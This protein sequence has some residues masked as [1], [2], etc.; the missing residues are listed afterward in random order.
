VA[1]PDI[2]DLNRL[3]EA[4]AAKLIIQSAR[5]IEYQQYYDGEF[6]IVALL[7]TEQ[8]RVFKTF[9]AESSS[10]WCELIVN[11]VAER[12]QVVGFRFDDEDAAD[13]VWEIWQANGLDADSELAQTDA[14]TMGS[15]FV[16]V[17]PDDDN[18]TGVCISVESPLQATVLY[19]PGNRRKRV[20]GYKCYGTDYEW[21]I[22]GQSVLAQ[23]SGAA[24]EILILPDQIVTWWPGSDRDAPQIE[25]NPLG[26]VGLVELV[27]QPRTLKPPR[28]ELAPAMSIQ[29]RINTTIFNRLV[30]TDYGA[31]R[32]ITAAGVKIGRNIIRQPDGTD[33]VQVVRPFDIGANRLLAS[34]DPATRFGSIPESQLTGYLASVEQDMHSLAAITQTPMHY[35]PGKMVNLAA[36]AIRAAEA[37]LVCKCRR[38]STHLGEGWEEV[39]RLALSAIG[40]PAATDTAAEVRWADMET[41]SEGQLVDALVKMATLKVPTVVLWE[42]WGATPQQIEQWPA[43]LAAEPAALTPAPPPAPGGPA[44]AEPAPEPEP[45]D[46]GV[47]ADA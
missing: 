6:P 46:D 4:A 36:D 39:A 37:G 16:L 8:R 34:E 42:R 28:S 2:A 12:L 38:R 5:S 11:A 17:Q 43:M 26:A 21:L 45:A 47:P 29:D 20:A 41:R 18:P 35:F 7:D 15:S 25:P 13:A 19:E 30:A 31:F 23:Q 40:N 10:N 33:A 1:L 24:V 32:T 3:R 44:P 14:L 9:L 27:P 22:T